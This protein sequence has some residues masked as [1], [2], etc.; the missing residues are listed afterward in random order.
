MKIGDLHL[1]DRAYQTL[2]YDPLYKVLSSM[3]L[4]GSIVEFE[5]LVEKLGSLQDVTSD[6]IFKI[7]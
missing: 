1:L 7:N 5:D 3:R 2:L 4:Y 6:D